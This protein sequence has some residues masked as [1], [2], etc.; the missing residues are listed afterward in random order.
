[1]QPRLLNEVVP[2]VLLAMK[3]LDFSRLRAMRDCEKDASQRRKKGKKKVKSMS[4][5]YLASQGND[6]I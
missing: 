3:E 1:V 5:S 6:V 4:T 2:S